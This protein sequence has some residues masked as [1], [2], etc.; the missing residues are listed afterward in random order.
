MVQPGHGGGVADRLP[1]EIGMI[2]RYQDVTVNGSKG[3]CSNRL[4]QRQRRT[5]EPVDPNPQNRLEGHPT[6]QQNEYRSQRRK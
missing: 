1:V 3:A 2:E 6:E 4:W 5:A